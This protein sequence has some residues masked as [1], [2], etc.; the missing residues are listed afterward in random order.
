MDVRAMLDAHDRRRAHDAERYATHHDDLCML[1]HAYG[2]DKRSLFLRC[3]YAVNEAVP[4]AIDTFAVETLPE[5]LR[6]FYYLRI[7]KS[8]RGRLLGHLRD[9]R[10]ECMVMRPVLKDHDGSPE[11]ESEEPLVPVRIDGAI[12]RMTQE[13]YERWKLE[14][15]AE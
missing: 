6:G 9:W 12:V 7:C 10:G 8:C 1:C 2:S 3:L 13:D 15:S 11:L 14:T 4:E 5:A